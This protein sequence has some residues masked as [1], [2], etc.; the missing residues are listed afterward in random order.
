M[1]SSETYLFLPL[2]HGKQWHFVGVPQYSDNH[3]IKQPT[4]ALDDVKMS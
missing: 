3:P 1:L 2:L 4:A